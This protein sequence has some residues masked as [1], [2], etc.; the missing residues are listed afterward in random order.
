MENFLEVKETFEKQKD[1]LVYGIISNPA[2][3][4]K[5]NRIKI[6]P[7][8]KKGELL[9]YTEKFTQKQAF[10]KNYNLEE[11]LDFLKEN[12]GT[13]FKNAVFVFAD[14]TLTLL[15]NKKGETKILHKKNVPNT[16][17]KSAK[18]EKAEKNEQLSS[19]KLEKNGGIKDANTG[20]GKNS[21]SRFL[22]AENTRAQNLGQNRSKNYILQPDVPVDFLVHLGVMTETGKVVAQKY[23]KFKQI[24]RFLEFV[25]DILPGIL[26]LKSATGEPVLN[27]VD[28][29]CG[30]SYLTFALYHYLTKIKNIKTFV[31]GLDLKAEVIELCNSLAKEF[32]YE[33]L[34]FST[35]DIA[36]YSGTGD[37]DLMVCL[38]ACD[39]ATDYAL[40]KAVKTNAKAILCVPCC[41]HEINGNLKN[42]DVSPQ[43]GLFL[44]YGII[45]ERFAALATD[46]MRAE[47]LEQAGYDVQMLEFIDMSHTPKNLLIRAVKK[48]GKNTKHNANSYILLRDALG[49]A[50]TLEKLL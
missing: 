27:V 20:S 46:L 32:N 22:A 45:K 11:F 5:F 16:A 40:E 3:N 36:N 49:T 18:V 24:N 48:Q 15:T 39:T 44:K 50:P 12:I 9:F 43:L 47:L 41:Q 31:T 21:K 8:I 35:G 13:N 29:G 28:F 34:H 42:P 30:K 19:I 37:I 2:K 4:S 1:S 6:K 33:N 17:A 14:E 25:D 10:Q 26:A 23:D 7:V 38:H